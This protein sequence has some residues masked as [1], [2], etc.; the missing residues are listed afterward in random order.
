MLEWNGNEKRGY[1]R[2]MNGIEQR[3]RKRDRE[4][5]KEREREWTGLKIAHL[6]FMVKA[7]GRKIVRFSEGKVSFKP[8]PPLPGSGRL[9]KEVYGQAKDSRCLLPR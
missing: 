7:S 4:R 9:E 3:E 2:E 6:P 8:P 5:E 1:F